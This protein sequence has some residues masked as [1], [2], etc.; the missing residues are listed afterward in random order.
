MKALYF[1]GQLR[2][3]EIPE[4]K[5]RENEAL[6]RVRY[7]GI[8]NTDLEIFKGYMGFNGVPGHEFVGEVVEAPDKGL[9]G[10]RVVG[11]I[12]IACGKCDMCL[13]GHRKHCRNIRTLGIN[14]WDGA[15][16]EYLKLPIENLHPVPNS[17][18]DIE[19]VFVEPLAA[20]VQVLEQVNFRPT[21]R[22]AVVGD[23]KLGLLIS[24]VLKAR[25]IDHILIGKHPSRAKDIV[26]GIPLAFPDR[27]Q[28][29][30]GQIDIAV[31]ATGN[32][33]GFALAVNIVKPTGTIVLKSTYA[34]GSTFDFSPVVVKELNVI[35]SRCGSF[36]PA[37]GFLE[38][39][40]VPVKSMVSAVY[41]FEEAIDAFSATPGALKVLLRF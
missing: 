1:D 4:P 17:I 32:S 20:A 30:S 14:N 31:E 29:L 12:N 15:F 28:E 16:A 34:S 36:K 33:Q 41:P 10:K 18:D 2:F 5:L 3:T 37:I 35:G 26:K 25:N 21:D 8:C 27:I 9:I 13:S 39:K 7:A 6:I 23:G 24:L 22:V 38:K 19:A 11:E 40:L